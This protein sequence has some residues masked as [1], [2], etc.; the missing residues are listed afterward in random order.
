MSSTLSLALASMAVPFEST[1]D[2][3]AYSLGQV[4]GYL[5]GVVILLA[6]LNHFLKKKP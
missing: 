5:I 2:S 4:A 3:L 1:D 6:I